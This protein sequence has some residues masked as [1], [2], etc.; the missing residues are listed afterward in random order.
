MSG[1]SEGRPHRTTKN[2][3]NR[4]AMVPF[5]YIGIRPRGDGWEVFHGHFIVATSPSKMGAIIRAIR[6]GLTCWY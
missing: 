1:W 5:R 6:Y 3:P 4:N 2:L